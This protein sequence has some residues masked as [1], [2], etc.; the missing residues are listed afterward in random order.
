MRALLVDD[1]A[2]MRHVYRRLLSEIDPELEFVEAVDG[3]DA[4]ETVARN[5]M[6]DL[7]VIDH[8]MPRM[9]GAEALVRLRAMGYTG[10]AIMSTS[11]DRSAFRGPILSGGDNLFVSKP[12]WSSRSMPVFEDSFRRLARFGLL[13]ATRR[14]S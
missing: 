5:G 10:T 2:T 3:V 6:P 1:S 11:E 4:L 14:A 9:D 13:T 8:Q 12:A 7:L